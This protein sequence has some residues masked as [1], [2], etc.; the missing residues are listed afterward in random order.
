MFQV[1]DFTWNGKK[2][3]PQQMQP[4]LSISSIFCFYIVEIVNV[5]MTVQW[6][7]YNSELDPSNELSFIL[8]RY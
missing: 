2:K 3:I 1:E 8:S 5:G 7:N 4:D 6:F